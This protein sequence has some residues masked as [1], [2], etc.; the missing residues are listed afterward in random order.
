MR[1]RVLYGDRVGFFKEM[2]SYLKDT[3]RGSRHGCYGRPRLYTRL[4]MLRSTSATADLVDGHVYGGIRRFG[5]RAPHGQRPMHSTVVAVALGLCQAFLVSEVNH[6]QPNEYLSE[7]MPLLAGYAAFQIGMASSCSFEQAE[8]GGSAMLSIVRLCGRSRSHRAVPPLLMFLRRD[9]N[10]LCGCG[11]DFPTEQVNKASAPGIE[12][13]LHTDSAVQCTAALRESVLDPT[14]SGDERRCRGILFRTPADCLVHAGESRVVTIVG[15]QPGRGRLCAAAAD[16]EQPLGGGE[17][18][19]LH[20]HASSMDGKPISRSTRPLL[21]H[22]PQANTGAKWND[23]H[24]LWAELGRAHAD[25]AGNRLGTA[26]QYRR[27]GRDAGDVL[28]RFVASHRRAHIGP[29]PGTRLGVPDWRL[30]DDHLPDSA[31][32]VGGLRRARIAAPKS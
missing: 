25:R 23:R 22:R 13:P 5:A 10:P 24:T 12:A 9:L 21:C 28:G 1:G 16:D 29:P 19:I 14:Y 30:D 18:R 6:P 32:S 3:L 20:H 17:Q 4:A 26:A 11:A 31:D 15:S 7:M 27:R 2:K 8:G